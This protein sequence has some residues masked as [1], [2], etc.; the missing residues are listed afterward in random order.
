MEDRER[1]GDYVEGVYLEA[2]WDAT[3]D[4]T[5]L[6]GAELSERLEELVRQE[7]KV[8]YRRRML[9]GEIDLIRAELVRRGAEG[10]SAE[11]LALALASALSRGTGDPGVGQ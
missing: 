10:A 2:D 3:E 5:A 6:S 1:A 8:S 4:L 9:H 7:R 11:D